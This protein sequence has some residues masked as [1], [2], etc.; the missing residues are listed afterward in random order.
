MIKVIDPS[1]MDGHGHVSHDLALTNLTQKHLASFS[2][3]VVLETELIHH[4][5]LFVKFYVHVSEM[6]DE[7]GE[8][9]VSGLQVLVLLGLSDFFEQRDNAIHLAF[10]RL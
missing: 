5:F 8:N 3:Q 10:L 1:P 6:S 9:C 4:S 2:T 7:V